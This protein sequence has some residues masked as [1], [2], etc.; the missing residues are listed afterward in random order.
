[1]HKVII[2]LFAILSLPISL[3][4]QRRPDTLTRQDTLRGS[5]TP[6]REWW[7]LIYYHLD[8]RVNPADSS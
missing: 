8:I 3:Q 2:F 5:I 1:M 4:A 6:E 7:D